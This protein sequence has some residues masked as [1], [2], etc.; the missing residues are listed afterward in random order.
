MSPAWR[1]GEWISVEDVDATTAATSLVAGFRPVG[2]QKKLLSCW[3]CG[4]LLL[5]CYKGWPSSDSGVKLNSQVKA[6]S[7]TGVMAIAKDHLSQLN[8]S[9]VHHYLITLCSLQ[10]LGVYKVLEKEKPEG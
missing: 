4:W 1:T 3:R 2:C 8:F 7:A 9:T 5:G 10:V 6:L